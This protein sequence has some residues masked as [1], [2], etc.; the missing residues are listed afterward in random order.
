[1]DNKLVEFKLLEGKGFCE[2]S[3]QKS[4]EELNEISEEIFQVEFEILSPTDII[5]VKNPEKRE[6]LLEAQELDNQISVIEAE[7]QKLN[8]D[9]D[10][11][12]NHADGWDYLIAVASGIITGLIDSFFVGELGLFDNASDIAKAKF[13]K[14]KASANK[15]INKYIEKYARL[16]GYKGDSDLK[17]CIEFLEKKFPVAQ[18]NTWKDKKISSAKAHHL[19][20]LAHHPSLL[21]LISAI[22]VQFF[23]V[24]VFANKDGEINFKFV[25]PTIADVLYIL[26][27]V[28]SGGIIKWMVNLAEKKY[29]DIV[30]C[31]DVPKPIRFLIEK[32]HKFPATI[33]ILKTADN[34]VGHLVSDMGGSKNTPGGGMGIPGLFGSL[35][36]EISML[37][38]IKDSNLPKLINDLY[39]HTKNSPLTDKLDLRTELAVFKTQGMP[40]ILND[41]IVRS[42]F[43]IRH[44]VEEIRTGKEA[45]DMDWKNIVPFG[46]RT[47]VRMMTIATGTFTA[48]DLADAAIRGA[49]SSG[50]NA[51]LFAKEMILR[52]N[53]VGVGRFAIAVVTDVGMGIKREKLSDERMKLYSEMLYLSNAKIFYL[54]AGMWKEAEETQIVLKKTWDIAE[55]SIEAA[56]KQ[57]S[58]IENKTENISKKI[59]TLPEDFKQELLDIL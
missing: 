18:D 53:F 58:E 35:L 12:T 16:R 59:S 17:K 2:E 21:G 7:I 6:F 15:D 39:Q 3:N 10:R 38:G 31:D 4:V 48:V 56:G 19:D 40:I 25:K 30:F 44:L 47:I 34:W 29:E 8:V 11:L 36:K 52:V 46:N 27:P 50:G 14:A 22:M 28:V 49:I 51:A 41:V 57:W 24:S 32:I 1:M 5:D 37:P 42:L 55:K 45:K 23:R 33:E 13:K 54:E 26:L 20:D 9:I 43:F